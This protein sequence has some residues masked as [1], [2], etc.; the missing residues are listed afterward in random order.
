M[1][2]VSSAS[3]QASYEKNINEENLQNVMG[4]GNLCKFSLMPRDNLCLN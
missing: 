2:V 1:Q 3:F 4:K